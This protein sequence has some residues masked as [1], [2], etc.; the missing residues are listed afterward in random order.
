MTNKCANGCDA[1]VCPPS[2]VICKACIEAISRRLEEANCEPLREATAR[3]G[4]AVE[5]KTDGKDWW[6]RWRGQP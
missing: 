3:R 4:L 2:K 6:W 1:P 5:V